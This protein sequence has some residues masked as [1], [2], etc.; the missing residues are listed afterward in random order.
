MS[1]QEQQNLLARL[2]TD[3]EFRRAFLS[4]AEKTVAGYNLSSQEIRELSEIMP[5]ELEFFADSLFWKRLR[6]TEKFLPLTKK[7]LNE[8][9]TTQFREFSQNFNPQ[10]VKKHFEDALEF[11]RFLQ[12]REISELAKTRRHLNKQSSNFSVWKGESLFAV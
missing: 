3:A 10:T 5:E 1:L 4:E 11:C 7:V 9:F 6:E 8:D 12:I 2:Y